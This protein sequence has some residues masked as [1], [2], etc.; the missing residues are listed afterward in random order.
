M[1]NIFI[2]VLVFAILSAALDLC[3]AAREL[4]DESSQIFDICIEPRED[5]PNPLV[6]YVCS[7]PNTS[8]RAYF[9]RLDELQGEPKK[10]A[11]LLFRKTTLEKKVMGKNITTEESLEY[12][13][14]KKEWD[15]IQDCWAKIKR[16]N[17]PEESKRESTS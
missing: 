3:A 4:S 16:V 11:D 15:K 9:K 7:S 8:C 1:K 12:Q 2:R 6:L 17:F 10:L 13:T 14:L 5:T